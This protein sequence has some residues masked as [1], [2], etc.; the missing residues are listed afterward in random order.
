[1]RKQDALSLA[2]RHA[3]AGKKMIL[4]VSGQLPIGHVFRAWRVADEDDVVDPEEVVDD[5][6]LVVVREATL[7]EFL[8]NRPA[9]FSPRPEPI[10][11]QVHYYEVICE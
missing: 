11:P 9:G 7:Q 8:E 3:Q 6:P 4:A 5:Q 1:M 2:A 10:P